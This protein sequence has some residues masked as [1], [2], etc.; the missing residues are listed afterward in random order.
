M[1]ALEIQIA[2]EKS[3]AL[4]ALFRRKDADPWPEY[5]KDPEEFMER[6]RQLID[7]ARLIYPNA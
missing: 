1:T 3:D 6:A 5:E 7:A 2:K 4:A